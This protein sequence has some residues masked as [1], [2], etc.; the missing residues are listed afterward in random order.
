MFDGIRPDHVGPAEIRFPFLGRNAWVTA[1]KPNRFVSK[2][3]CHVESRC[4][5]TRVVPSRGLMPALLMRMSR[6]PC[7]ASIA[8]AA[9]AM[10]SGSV[11]A[12]LWVRLRHSHGHG[13]PGCANL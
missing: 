2:T 7:L 13:V 11:T 4:S 5:D 9:A 8:L 6:H 1:I 12:G 10:L 3:A